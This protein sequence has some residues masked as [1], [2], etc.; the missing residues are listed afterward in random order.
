MLIDKRFKSNISDAR[1]TNKS[2]RWQEYFEELLNGE[3][4]V[5]PIPA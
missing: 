3:I 5:T 2:I 4:P 1:P